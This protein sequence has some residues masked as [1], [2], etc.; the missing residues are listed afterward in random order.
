MRLRV[1][2]IISNLKFLIPRNSF[3]SGIFS[4]NNVV[5]L[6]NFRNKSKF[7]DKNASE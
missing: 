5:F 3:H 1:L 4:D 6:V 2:K 7:K